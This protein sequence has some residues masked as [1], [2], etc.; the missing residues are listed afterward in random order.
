MGFRDK[1]VCVQ[2]RSGAPH[3]PCGTRCFS[4]LSPAPSWLDALTGCPRTCACPVAGRSTP[5]PGPLTPESPGARPVCLS[6]LVPGKGLGVCLP[7]GRERCFQVLRYQGA[8]VHLKRALQLVLRLRISE[9]SE[10]RPSFPAGHLPTLYDF[11]FDSTRKK[12]IPWNQL[13]PDYVHSPE[14]KFIDILGK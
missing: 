13:V 6:L 10:V 11:H 3:T 2:R 14:R 4:D 9:Q 1:G 8:F 7:S 12:W 5:P